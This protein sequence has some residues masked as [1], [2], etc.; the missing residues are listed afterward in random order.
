M[1]YSCYFCSILFLILLF[2]IFAFH[3]SHISLCNSIVYIVSLLNSIFFQEV[4]CTVCKEDTLSDFYMA[5]GCN[6]SSPTLAVIKLAYSVFVPKYGAFD[7]R[8][9]NC[10]S[11]CWCHALMLDLLFK[12]RIPFLLYYPPQ[13]R[14]VCNE[15]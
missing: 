9:I 6:P 12:Y 2:L 5:S 4:F 13:Y 15:V 8:Y 10:G 14:S 7:K 3:L 11:C 1:L